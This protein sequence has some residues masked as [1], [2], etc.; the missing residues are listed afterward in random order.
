MV[1]KAISLIGRLPPT[2]EDRSLVVNMRR[3]KQGETCKRFSAIDPH[4][5]LELLGQKTA[6]WVK[7]NFD[8]LRRAK[9]VADG[10]D[11]RIYDNWMPLLAI[12]DR[13]GGAWP[14]WVRIAALRFVAKSGRLA[15]YQGRAFDGHGRSYERT[16]QDEQ[17]GSC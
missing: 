4:P 9:P 7:D 16:G 12:A 8:A 1:S 6:R 14:E 5:E 10:I 15:V 11:L 2:L 3:R 13:A 17:R